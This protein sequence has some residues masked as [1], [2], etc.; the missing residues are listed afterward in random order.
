MAVG[1]PADGEAQ[2]RQSAEA[3]FGG[4]QV[5]NVMALAKRLG[6][7]PRKLAENVD[8]LLEVDGIACKADLAGPDVINIF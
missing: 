3:Q 1:A 6:M 8:G 2:V 4:Y 7:P 5:T